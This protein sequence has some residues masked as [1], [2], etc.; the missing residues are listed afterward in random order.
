MS[1]W[2]CRALYKGHVLL[3]DFDMW[4][5]CTGCL[6]PSGALRVLALCQNSLHCMCSKAG[7]GACLHAY[8]L[9]WLLYN[10]L[11]KQIDFSSLY[12]FYH[13]AISM[14]LCFYSQYLEF[15]MI[16]CPINIEFFNR[17]QWYLPSRSAR[18]SIYNS[19]KTT[20]LPVFGTHCLNG[21]LNSL[22]YYK[23]NEGIPVLPL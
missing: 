22:L 12:H 17:L 19:G 20:P 10:R 9:Y 23:I 2:S 11:F 1:T 14:R 13:K 7:Q 18:P 6:L 5:S 15:R 4:Y 3:T 8:V 21:Q 16:V